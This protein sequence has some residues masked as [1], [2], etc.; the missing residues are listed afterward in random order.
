MGN[1]RINV[2]PNTF[3]PFHFSS[4]NHKL[5]I[6]SNYLIY[7]KRRDVKE[8][9]RENI[10]RTNIAFKNYYLQ[11]SS[12]CTTCNFPPILSTFWPSPHLLYLQP[13]PRH[14][15]LLMELM[16]EP[17]K[18]STVCPWWVYGSQN[19]PKHTW[20]RACLSLLP[21]PPRHPAWLRIPISIPLSLSL[22]LLPC[23]PAP[24]PPGCSSGVPYCIP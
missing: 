3:P 11:L 7:N 13:D 24:W 17:P 16:L 19:D 6:G 18:W 22:T 8:I 20:I 12:T 1:S 9:M 4:E 10:N 2:V 23:A 21:C 15:L 5:T 14:H